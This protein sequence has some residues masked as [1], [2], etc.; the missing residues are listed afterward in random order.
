M[1]K[2]AKAKSR[3]DKYYELAKEQGYRSRA[4]FKLLQLDKKFNFLNTANVLIDLCAAPGG[5]LQ[6]AANNMPVASMIIG[7]DLVPIK[8]IKGVVTFAGDITAPE[9]H[10]RIR[11][12]LKTMKADVVLHDGAPNVGVNWLKDAY[13]QNELVLTSLKVAIKFLREGGTFVT[14]IFRSTDYNSLLWL[15]GKLFEKVSATKPLASRSQSAEIFVVCEKYKAPK[16]IDPKLLDPKYVFIDID[17]NI[18]SQQEIK[19]LKQ[20]VPKPG[21]LKKGKI[22]ETKGMTQFRRMTLAEFVECTNPYQFLVDTNQITFDDEDSKE[23]LEI[24]PAPKGLDALCEDIKLLGRNE[25]NALLKWRHKVKKTI[26]KKKKSETQVETQHEDTDSEAELEE[27]IQ[28]LKKKEKNELKKK[29]EK[30]KKEAKMRYDIYDP[31]EGQDL[32]SIA[33]TENRLDGDD[34]DPNEPNLMDQPEE[35]EDDL[36]LEYQDETARIR[37]MEE[38]LNFLHSED[39]IRKKRRLND[40]LELNLVK[41][42][43]I[44][45][46]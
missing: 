6:V 35:E 30:E 33:E 36:E 23:Y 19:S 7:V 46:S 31:Y 8:P 17:E 34:F 26:D 2:K 28:S 3:L 20:I 43:I 32:Y 21:K 22:D 27:R 29:R 13:D 9:T 39:K 38:N 4:A 40:E 5:W 24:A 16:K 42:S 18:D 25:L 1:V 44:P 14:K 45:I 15:F 10:N 41:T 12:E 37:I 11:A